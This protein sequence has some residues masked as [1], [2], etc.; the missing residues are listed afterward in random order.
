MHAPDPGFRDQHSFA[1]PFLLLPASGLQ[2][3]QAAGGTA[4]TQDH[5]ATTLSTERKGAELQLFKAPLSHRSSPCLLVTQ[6]TQVPYLSKSVCM[7]FFH[8]FAL[9]SIYPKLNSRFPPKLV[10][11]QPLHICKPEI[12][13]FM[14]SSGSPGGASGKELGCQ[15]RRHKR[16]QSLGREDPLEDGMATHCSILAWRIPQESLAGYSPC[17]CK[18]ADMSGATQHAHMNSPPPCPL[19]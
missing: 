8:H 19:H 12:R 10:L 2:W 14:N 16:L 9:N 15:Y 3:R 17:G 18:E 1:A 7:A 13:S 11:C 6:D 4:T 5:R